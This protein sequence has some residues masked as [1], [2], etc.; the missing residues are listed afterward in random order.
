[1]IETVG[2]LQCKTRT[3]KSSPDMLNFY[4]V[5]AGHDMVTDAGKVTTRRR[6]FK[7]Q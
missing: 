5:S 4:V 7:A 2:T 1:M 3:T 6:K